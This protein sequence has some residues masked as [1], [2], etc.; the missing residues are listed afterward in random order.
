MNAT[1]LKLTPKQ[2][3]KFFFDREAVTS[4]LTAKQKNV[5]SRSGAFVMTTARGLIRSPGKK[6]KSAR[7]GA[8]PK[9]QTGLLKNHIYFAYDSK[10]G[11]VV[12]GPAKLNRLVDGTHSDTALRALELG[13]KTTGYLPAGVIVDDDGQPIRDRRE[14]LQQLRNKTATVNQQGR[15]TTF[16]INPHP[17]MA[18]AMRINA[19]K[20]AA[21]W[22]GL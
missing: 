12:V 20:L 1:S 3:A 14:A 6:G 9:S 18:P 15:T 10:T 7:S 17:F 13:G 4:L 8:P 16:Q 2:T 19:D 5:M 22:A 21:M 11:G